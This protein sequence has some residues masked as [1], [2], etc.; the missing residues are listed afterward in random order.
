MSFI[1]YFLVHTSEITCLNTG[2]KDQF[3]FTIVDQ[4]LRSPGNRLVELQTTFY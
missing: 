2:E 3:M 1:S 4:F